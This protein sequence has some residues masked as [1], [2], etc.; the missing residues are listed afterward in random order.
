MHL[1]KTL[2]GDAT[3][4]VE[5][6]DKSELL[7]E[8]DDEELLCFML[9]ASVVL[10]PADFSGEAKRLSGRRCSTLPLKQNKII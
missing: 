7:L 2:L 8:E 4:K 9:P 3:F 10:S 1:E 5:L 6:E